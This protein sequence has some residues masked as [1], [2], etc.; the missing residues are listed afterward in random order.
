[1]SPN[2]R[3]SCAAD[4]VAPA[5]VVKNPNKATD[6]HLEEE[7]VEHMGEIGQVLSI[8]GAYPNG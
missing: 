2:K 4:Q 5:V 8:L 3:V 7:L 1:M 6:D